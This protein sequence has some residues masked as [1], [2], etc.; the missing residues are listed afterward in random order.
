MKKSLILLLIFSCILLCSCGSNSSYTNQSSIPY[1]STEEIIEPTELYTSIP[2][3]T[4]IATE[5][6][7]I[8][9]YTI[10]FIEPTCIEKGYDFY[11]CECGDS[12]IENYVESLGHSYLKY[13]IDPTYIASGYDYYVC[14]I[15]GHEYTDNWVEKIP[16]NCE[17]IQTVIN[18]TCLEK[19]YTENKCSICGI[20]KKDNYVD[21]LGHEYKVEVI[22][23]TA[24]SYGYDLHTC[25]RCFYSYKDNYKD[26]VI[27]YEEVNETVYAIESVNI[28]K[29]PGT[30]YEKV[31]RL[32]L[33]Q[34]IIRTGIGN[35]GWS[36]VLYNNQI[37]YIYSSYLT[38][39]KPVSPIEPSE[40]VPVPT[41]W[42]KVYSDGTC[43]ITIYKE[44]YEDAYVYAAHLQ[45]TDYKRF[46]TDCAKGVYNS[47]Y[48]TTSQAARRL[49]AIFCVNGDYAIP[50]NGA[51][52]YC[53]A[54]GGKVCNDKKVYSEG[55]YNFN[56][57]LLT[58]RTYDNCAGN[59]LSEMVEA[60]KIT[61]TFQFGPAFLLGGTVYGD[62]NST[63]R[64]QRT[65]IG[66]N[67]A[68]GDIWVCVSDGRYNDGKSAGLNGYQC[69]SYLKSKGCVFGI[70]LDGGGSSTMYF[71]GQVL[72]AANG[73][74][75]YVADF[76]YLK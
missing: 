29:G 72:N 13:V 59:L 69:A 33:G 51:G 40:P 27:E 45:F 66:T 55:I 8:H 44:W 4:E 14:S 31:G 25:I 58:Y 12:Y 74:E 41:G 22:P 68:P 15:C 26:P 30:N 17:Y 24:T 18:P 62:P 6:Q 47:G 2:E 71:N 65:F 16:H 42:P 32:D 49:G 19:G 56:T 3:D 54:R 1:Q 61:D 5:T 60:G 10:I 7:H 76:V 9:N 38:L 57:G 53:V 11:L 52:S 73:N 43:T 75:R 37:C 64:A 20:I 67:G 28:R 70:P 35:N 23:S 36:R 46:G 21:P 50:A 48:E 39:E 34:E 63:G